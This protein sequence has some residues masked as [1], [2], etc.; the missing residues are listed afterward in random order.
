[1]KK[2][3]MMENLTVYVHKSEY[4]I[5]VDQKFTHAKSLEDIEDLENPTVG[6]FDVQSLWK[7]DNKFYLA[8]EVLDGYK[9]LIEAKSYERI[10]KLQLAQ[11]VLDNDPLL[12]GKT[13]LDLNNI[14]FKDFQD[15][16]LLYRSNGYLPYQDIEPLEQYK[17]FILGFISEK[18]GYKKYMVQRDL[19]LKKE[20][21]DFMFAVNAAQS[22]SKLKHIVSQELIKTQS[23]YYTQLQSSISNK[24]TGKK[25]KIIMGITVL[26][27]L[28]LLFIGGLKQ[29]EKNV[30]LQYEEDIKKVQLDNDILKAT[31]SGDTE[32]AISLMKKNKVNDLEIAQM[33]VDAGKYQEAIDY[34]KDM[35]EKVVERL[36]ELGQQ[37]KI[38]TLKSKSDFL[39][40]EKDI[41]EYDTNV[42]DPQ[43][44][45]IN[46]KNTLKR[47]GLTYIENDNLLMA[48][49][50][51]NQL[52]DK[53]LENYIKK[54]ALE[55]EIN[56]LNNKLYELEKSNPDKNKNTKKMKGIEENVRSLQKELIKLEEKMGIDS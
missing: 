28:S 27:L 11:K 25:R 22:F 51:Q 40:T 41:I 17:L 4:K 47:L 48:K 44:T 24:K 3:T 53:E 35:E 50:V 54:Y 38:L 21:D 6:F 56:E 29:K 52:K 20:N 32:K 18:Y 19:L 37:D 13:T 55:T 5:E 36:Y 39:K 46:N 31:Q 9:P 2:I 43:V 45:L 30:A 10:I 14:F 34:N 12:V 8:Y 7:K 1:M 15:I 42:L 26:L 23:E 49:E 33:L 16:K